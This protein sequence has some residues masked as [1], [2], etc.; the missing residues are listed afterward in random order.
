MKSGCAVQSRLSRYLLP[1]ICHRKDLLKQ[2]EFLCFRHPSLPALEQYY[3]PFPPSSIPGKCFVSLPR[4]QAAELARQQAEVL[5][6]G[7]LEKKAKITDLSPSEI[8][9]AAPPAAV[10]VNPNMD[11]MM[12]DFSNNM[13]DSMTNE[14]QTDES[15]QVELPIST[16]ESNPESS[17]PEHVFVPLPTQCCFCSTEST[18]NSLQNSLRSLPNLHQRMY[19]YLSQN[20]SQN[21]RCRTLNGNSVSWSQAS[22]LLGVAPSDMMDDPRW[23]RHQRT[24]VC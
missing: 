12:N 15:Q 1:W 11:D 5:G 21:L 16:S 10:E 14:I 24:G 19:Q 6:V 18:T 20:L 13:L 4:R 9:V 2:S 3:L 8:P 22:W 17:V 23:E 7:R